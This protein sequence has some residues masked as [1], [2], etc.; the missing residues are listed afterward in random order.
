MKKDPEFG[1]DYAG[2]LVLEAEALGV[3]MR[4]RIRTRRIIESTKLPR[5]TDWDQFYYRFLADYRMEVTIDG[6][7]AHA[8]G[9][10][11]HELMLL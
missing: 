6:A 1:Q 3:G 8:E 2:A 5:V 9:E 11:L 7:R 10:M 4:L